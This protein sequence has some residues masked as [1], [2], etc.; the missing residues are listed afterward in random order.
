MPR[1]TLYPHLLLF[2][3]AR[4]LHH[5]AHLFA[6]P[7]NPYVAQIHPISTQHVRHEPFFNRAKI[8]FTNLPIVTQNVMLVRCSSLLS[9]IFHQRYNM[10][11]CNF[12]Y[13]SIR[14]NSPGF[15]F[16]KVQVGTCGIVLGYKCSPESL[17]D[18]YDMLIPWI[19]FSSPLT[20]TCR[21]EFFKAF[22][23]F[24]FQRP[25]SALHFWIL[26]KVVRHGNTFLLQENCSLDVSYLGFGL[27][28]F[29]AAPNHS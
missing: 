15:R 22:L 6:L 4:V 19:Q 20:C 5:R 23:A 24:F 12:F 26:P 2:W 18:R 21:E 11:T 27:N 16:M 10:N 9:F 29:E 13:C 14:N 1:L 17:R 28:F 3:G 25:T 7:G 8:S